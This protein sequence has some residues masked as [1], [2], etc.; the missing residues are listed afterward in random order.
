MTTVKKIKTL[1]VDDEPVARQTIR[2]LLE[3]DPEIEVV[4]ECSSGLEAISS[5]RQ[6]TPDLLFLDI[7]MPRVNGF[8]V[9]SKTVDVK[10]PA[11]I[12]VTAFDQY[13]L[14]AFEVHALDY[15][16]K[17][18]T[19]QRFMDALLKAKS[20]LKMKELDRLSSSLLALLQDQPARLESVG[21]RQ[22]FLTRFMI[23][24]NGRVVFVTADSVDWIEAND[25]YVNVHVGATTHLI[26]LTMNELEQKLDPQE[27]FRIHRSLIVNLKRVKELHQHFN[28][29]Y[30][31][32]LHDGT[33]LK[34]SRGRRERLNEMLTMGTV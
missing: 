10:I 15:L 3:K 30:V 5:I 8:D 25:Y 17:P 2:A 14:N 19:D 27:F 33:E 7:Q 16:L 11:I 31:V 26:R 22:T 24:R 6:Q 12:F 28:G 18:Y 20:Q 32:I 34:L 13:A 4:G 21:S 23:K 1:I 29:E 9:L